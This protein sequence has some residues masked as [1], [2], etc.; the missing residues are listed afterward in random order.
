MK[1]ILLIILLSLMFLLVA[2]GSSANENSDKNENANSQSEALESDKKEESSVQS[3]ELTIDTLKKERETDIAEFEYFLNDNGEYTISKYLGS[4]EIVVIPDEIEGIPV[5]DLSANIFSYNESL[6]GIRI[7]NNIEK[8]NSKTF[9]GCGSLK[10]VIFGEKVKSV[11]ELCF[12]GCIELTEVILNDSLE[13]IE[14]CAF[15]TLGDKLSKLDIPKSVNSIEQAF[16]DPTTIYVEKGS[17][18]ETW[19]INFNQ[20]NPADEIKYVVE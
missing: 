12:S 19:V 7:G 5:T 3:K 8:I 4:N 11:G 2:C 10:Y 15:V 17:Y 18:A 20:E 13:E 6:K 14:F 1:K 16:V 9:M